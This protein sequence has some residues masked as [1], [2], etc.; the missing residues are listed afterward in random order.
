MIYGS[1][2]IYCYKQLKKIRIYE[3]IMAK[4]TTKTTKTTKSTKAQKVAKTTKTTQVVTSE[5]DVQP[6]LSDAFGELLAQVAVLRTQLT[7]L[8][9]QVRTLQKRTER[10]LRAAHKVSR[11]RQKA[12][13]NRAPSG[14]VKPTKI[15]DEL[16]NFLG[17]P[18]SHSL[19]SG[20][21]IVR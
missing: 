15:S 10:E 17:K 9:G 8:T 7:A 6:P 13:G 16:A 18:K 5:K 20:L 19:T 2:N 4:K 3:I 14:F 11:K 1:N 12:K 21:I